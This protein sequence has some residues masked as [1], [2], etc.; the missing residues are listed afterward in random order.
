MQDI[1]RETDSKSTFNGLCL[2][3]VYGVHSEGRMVDVLLFNGTPLEKVQVL[4][5]YGSS[6]VGST[7]LPIPKYIKNDKEILMT[8]RDD[9]LRMAQK[10]ESDIFCVVGYLG[11]YLLN[12]IVLGFLFPEECELLCGT[13][14]IGNKDG[15]MFLWKHESNVYARVAKGDTIDQSSEIE[16][17]H[18]S[19]LLIK[20]GS[21]DTDKKPDEQRTPIVNWD[22]LND[23]RTFNPLNP[24]TKKVDPAPWVHLYHPSGT[25]LTVDNKGNVDIVVIGDVT[26]TV[27]KDDSGD[28]GNVTEVIE[29]DV[30]RTIQGNVTEEIDGTLD[31]TIKKKVTQVFEDDFDKTVQKDVKETLEGNVTK[32]V[33]GTETDTVTGAWQRNSSDSI[34]DTAPRIDHD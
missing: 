15:S 10:E 19:G 4:T 27:K 25:Y 11:G 14:Q 20:I 2:G 33:S 17:S 23:L 8:E 9:P 3:K 12:P 5:L 28:R 34:K 22:S 26:K 7:G 31:Q 1:I 6:R 18:P 32:D 16:V 30:H 29:G 21:Y 24:D 13:D